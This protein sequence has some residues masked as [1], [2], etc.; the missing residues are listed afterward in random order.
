MI[1]VLHIGKTGGSALK[2]GLHAYMERTEDERFILHSHQH[3]L[4]S[5]WAA[6]PR[7]PVFFAVRDPITRFASGFNSRLRHGRPRYNAAW[8]DSEAAA[9]SCFTS[10]SALEEALSDGERRDAAQL[11]K[12]PRHAS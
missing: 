12:C 11:T 2:D 6:D 8:T 7:R 9:F 3:K 5:I 1:S 4:E 10:P